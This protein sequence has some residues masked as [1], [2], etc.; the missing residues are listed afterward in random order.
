MTRW[1]ARADALA[2]ALDAARDASGVAAL[3]GLPGVVGPLVDHLEIEP[4]AEAAVS[5]VLG[6]ALRAVVVDGPASAAPGAHATRGGRRGARWSWLPGRRPACRAVATPPAGTRLLADCVSSRVPGLADAVT[7]M[8][9]GALL[10]D[11][12]WSVAL[13]LVLADP[14]LTVVTATGDRFGGSGSWRL[15]GDALAASRAA[16][17]EARQRA[18]DALVERDASEAALD[19]HARGPRRAPGLGGRGGRGGTARRP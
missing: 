10:T 3:D 14:A 2:M 6:E 9:D 8:L 16:L 11:E 12:E 4:G 15:G 17:D 19:G 7:R 18:V 1:Q 13:E 5:A